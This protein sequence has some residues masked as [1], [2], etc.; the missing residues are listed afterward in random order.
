MA[1]LPL[2]LGGLGL[3]S[4]PRVSKAAYWSS[5][6][7]C[8]QTTAKRQLAVAEQLVAALTNQEPGRHLESTVES[9]ERLLDAGFRA[10]V[11]RDFTGDH[12]SP[13]ALD[14]A[15]PGSRLGW[16]QVSSNGLWPRL[17]PQSTALFRSQGRPSASV[18]YTCFPIAPHWST[19]SRFVSCCCAA[20]GCLF[21]PPL[22]TAGVAG[23][24]QVHQN[25]FHQNPLSSKS[26]FIKNHFH[27]KPLSS[28]TTFIKNHFHQKTNFIKKPLS[29]KCHFHQKPLSSKTTFIKNHFHQKPFSSK[30]NFTRALPVRG[31]HHPSKNN[32]VRVCVKASRAEGPRRL[33]TNTACAHLWGL[34]WPFC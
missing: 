9:R 33:H 26:T 15:E 8:V 3:R 30:T 7:E 16:Q 34:S 11:W 4:A 1:N 14:D 29:S 22:A 21:P 19:L 32:V 2:S 27:Q 18:P 28:K 12:P 6:A 23:K 10:P 20:S 25:H 17:S 13:H 24:V 5:W 31:T